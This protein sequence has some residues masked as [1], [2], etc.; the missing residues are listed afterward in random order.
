MH[1]RSL[2]SRQGNALGT[3]GTI[4]YS[5]FLGLAAIAIGI[6]LWS[7]K[8]QRHRLSLNDYAA[9]LAWVWTST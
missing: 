6:R 4:I 2:G 3:L 7:R 9:V 1:Q 8:I 5:L